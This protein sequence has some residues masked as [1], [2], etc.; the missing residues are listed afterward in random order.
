MPLTSDTNNSFS[1]VLTTSK[2][3]TGRNKPRKKEPDLVRNVLLLHRCVSF[4]IDEGWVC[5]KIPSVL[6]D[7]APA[8]NKQSGEPPIRLPWASEKYGE[9]KYDLKFTAR[10]RIFKGFHLLK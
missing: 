3:R 7:K 1:T 2:I 5:H 8:H 9:T 10:G 4:G 6:H